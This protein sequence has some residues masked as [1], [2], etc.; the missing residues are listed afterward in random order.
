MRSRLA[1]AHP[2]IERRLPPVHSGAQVSCAS[3]DQRDQLSAE[4]LGVGA[5]ELRERERGDARR[6]GHETL[7]TL[8]TDPTS[9][10]HA[11]AVGPPRLAPWL[12][13]TC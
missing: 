4:R 11:V 10:T 12:P 3:L 5:R 13:K 8:R 1:K 9:R 6:G 2:Y 7:R